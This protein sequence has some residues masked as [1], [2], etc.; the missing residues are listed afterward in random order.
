MIGGAARR[1]GLATVAAQDLIQID[2]SST[3]YP[4]TEAMAEEFQLASGGKYRVT[5][6][7]SGTGGGFKKF[8]RGETAHLGCLAADQ[9]VGARGAARRRASSSSSC[10]WRS[11]R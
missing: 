11:T 4:I 10:R 3:V 7:I 8:C 1:Q 2:G 9:G 5:V 6:G